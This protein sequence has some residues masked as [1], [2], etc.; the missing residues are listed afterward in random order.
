MH[1]G[2]KLNVAPVSLAV[3]A[4]VLSVSAVA[5]AGDWPQYRYDAGRTAASPEKLPARLHVQWVREYPMP[6]PAFP[7][8]LRL[9][10][11]A[12]YEPVVLR[13]TI[14]VPSMITDSVTA[15]D[16]ETGARRWRFFADGPVRFAP[17]AA[18]GKVYFVSDDGYL[19]C[20]GAADGKLLWKYR[21]L[22]PGVTERKVMGNRRLIALR[23]ARGGPVL[24]DGVIYFAAGIWPETGTFVH[25][26]K[27]D[28]G[29]PLWS[30]AKVTLVQKANLDHGVRSPAGLTPQGYLA[31][32]GGKLVVPCGRQLPAFLDPS[33]GKLDG[34][35]MGWG[36][37]NGLPKGS[38]FVAGT[39]NY[40]L[41]SGDLYDIGRPD[42]ERFRGSRTSDLYHPG[43]FTRLQ[44]DR[45][46]QKALGRF[47]VPVLTPAVMYCGTEDG[48]IAAYDLTKPKMGKRADSKIPN[49]RREDKFPDTWRTTFPELWRGES[50]LKLHIKAGRRLYVGGVGVVAAI[51]IPEAT[52]T[53]KVSWR[54]KIEGTPHRMLAADGKLFVVTLEGRIYAFGADGDAAATV[55]KKPTAGP[56][57][58]A[59]AWTE[60]AAR[61]LKETHVREGYALVL[62]VGTGRLAEELVRQSPVDVIVIDP[63]R[64]KVAALRKRFCEAGIYGTRIA[65]HEGDPLSYPFPPYLASLIVSEDLT[66]VTDSFDGT[67]AEQVFHPLRPYGGTACLPIPAARQAEFIKQLSERDLPAAEVRRAGGM[68]L[69]TRRGPLPGAADWSHEGADAAN[70]AASKDQFV[71]GDLS[72]LWHDGALRWHRQPG[73]TRVRVVG[74]RVLIRGQ[75]LHA[76]DVFTGKQLWETPTGGIGDLA[77]VDDAIYAAAGKACL[78][79]DP[80]TGRR[81]RQIQLPAKLAGSWSRLRISGDDLFATVGATVV[82]VDRHSGQLRW[83]HQAGSSRLSLAVGGGKVFCAEVPRPPDRRGKRPDNDPGRTFALDVE[84]GE[85][86]WQIPR[87]AELHYSQPHDL[88]ITPVGM[89]RGKDGKRAGDSKAAWCIAGNRFIS[90]VP[91]DITIHDLPAGAKSGAPVQWFRRGCTS[92]RAS[93]HLVTTRYGGN[94]AYI[95]LET[96]RITPVWGIRAAC[97]NNLFPANG[98]LNIPNL[99]GGC[100]CNYLSTSLAL[101]PTAVIE[102]KAAGDK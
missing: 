102:R 93:H 67:F 54:A 60:T 12:S 13:K 10:Y 7:A 39:G 5:I 79:L 61:I 50:K 49:Y 70:T 97:S 42:D 85:P 55:H 47:R 91:Q 62:G 46:C 66:G 3:A 76:I 43:G 100:T 24:K 26:L 16:T 58:E 92:L 33:S 72:L 32:I 30:N 94:A 37:R 86:V 45:T 75:K 23:P 59:D 29:K 87:G 35:T 25:A 4:L 18:K 96:R 34:Y 89:F 68:V 63:D 99:T 84:T 22:P 57:A 82:C 81:L 56:G 65:V 90:G 21:F 52:G 27:A 19:Y 9:C 20:V 80:A 95:D 53:S 14:F 8:E 15:L 71:K 69:L 38:W 83:S 48:Q 64:E 74:G 101:V 1:A 31:L 40:L 2:R 6:R 36:G 51:D 78:V 98:V 17:V 41:H 88:L 77:A 28:T 11:D 44:I 73:R